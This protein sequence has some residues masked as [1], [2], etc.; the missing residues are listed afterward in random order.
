MATK[1]D[2]EHG[3]KYNDNGEFNPRLI[4]CDHCGDYYEPDH[5]EVCDCEK[6]VIGDWVFTKRGE[7]VVMALATLILLTIMVVVGSIE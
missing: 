7:R 2:W 1:I 5:F 6:L 3:Q 4:S